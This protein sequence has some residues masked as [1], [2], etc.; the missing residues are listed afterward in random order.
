[1]LLTWK[2]G[3]SNAGVKPLPR[4]RRPCRLLPLGGQPLLEAVTPNMVNHSVHQVDGTLTAVYPTGIFRAKLKREKA[5]PKPGHEVLNAYLPLAIRGL[6]VHYWRL[7]G[8]IPLGVGENKASKGVP[9]PQAWQVE[10][11]S[12]VARIH[13]VQATRW[14]TGKLSRAVRR[15]AKRLAKSKVRASAN[16]LEEREM[17][18]AATSPAHLPMASAGFRRATGRPRLLGFSITANI[19]LRLSARKGCGPTQY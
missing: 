13:A 16:R 10:R 8:R 4:F 9:C 18:L 6:P 5:G 19:R 3:D 7:T 11:R 12:L 15:N 2:C 1:M 14:C 17:L